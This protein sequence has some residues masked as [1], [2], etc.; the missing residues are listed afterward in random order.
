MG[1]RVAGKSAP[2]DDS[3]GVSQTQ[4]T[5]S[6]ARQLVIHL[7]GDIALEKADDVWLGASL[8]H[9]AFEV[10][11]GVRVMGDAD[12]DDAPERAV[13]VAIAPTVES[14]TGDLS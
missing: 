3:Y 13:G 6:A 4:A 2:K 8:L 5:G 11:R 10:D 14:V 9:F 12:H 1:R 7:A